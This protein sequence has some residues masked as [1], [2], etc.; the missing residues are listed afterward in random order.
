M[1]DWWR[2]MI[3]WITRR[4]LSI[5]GIA[6]TSDNVSG[7]ASNA[8]ISDCFNLPTCVEGSAFLRAHLTE[9]WLNVAVVVIFLLAAPLWAMAARRDDGAK[10]VLE[11]GWS[12][13][14]FS[15]LISSTG[16]FILEGAIKRFPKIAV[17]QPVINGTLNFPIKFLCCFIMEAFYWSEFNVPNY[18]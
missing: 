2:D 12:P 5:I 1:M 9:S 14:I 18:H 6:A 13:I 11:N 10:D 7:G 17:F 3:H 8:W 15:M 16:G 4:I